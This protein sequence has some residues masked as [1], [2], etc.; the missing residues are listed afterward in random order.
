MK[1]LN[2]LT[3]L[4]GDLMVVNIILSE[5]ILGSFFFTE[6]KIEVYQGSSGRRDF[7][8]SFEKPLKY[9]AFTV[10]VLQNRGLK[11][12]QL[13]F[14]L[15]LDHI[16]IKNQLDIKGYPPSFTCFS[17]S[18][19]SS[20]VLLFFYFTFQNKKIKMLPLIPLH[21]SPSR[22]ICKSPCDSFVVSQIQTNEP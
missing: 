7:Y 15:K 9:S 17:C 20:I 16:D 18:N 14:K 13:I 8:Y 19:L 11:I 5:L 4:T 12:S 10:L 2:C 3:W 21:F 6:R 1:F 22:C